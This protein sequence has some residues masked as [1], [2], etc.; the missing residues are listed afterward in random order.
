V[1]FNNRQILKG[2]KLTSWLIAFSLSNCLDEHSS[3]I[4]Q[5]LPSLI[6]TDRA[7]QCCGVARYSAAMLRVTVLRCCALQ[8]CDVVDILTFP[9]T[10]RRCF[11]IHL[12]F[13]VVFLR[14][15]GDKVG[16]G[17]RTIEL[18]GRYRFAHRHPVS[19]RESTS[20]TIER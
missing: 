6:P 1:H 7:L 13:C 2:A 5:V 19:F 9:S 3:S 11:A 10:E 12:L 8:C 18:F 16:G 4:H 17:W 15:L 20:N 14:R